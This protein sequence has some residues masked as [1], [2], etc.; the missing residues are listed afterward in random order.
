M[1]V[2]RSG[3]KAH[4]QALCQFVCTDPPKA[5]Y[6]EH[7]GKHHP[8]PW[9]LEVQSHLR[10]QRLPA[11]PGS[12]IA[13]GFDQQGLSAVVEY[14]F[15]RSEEQFIITAL[16]VAQRCQRRRYGTEALQYVLQ[17]LRVTRVNEGVDCGVFARIDPRND[18]S[19][20]L[21]DRAGFEY[22]GLFGGYEM[23]VSDL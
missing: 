1:L 15:S 13:L 23:W 3:T 10:G 20:S 18:A 22:I 5:N 21:F 9:E 17:S 2:W 4:Q 11:P 16:A 19:R 6:D 7:R 12:A 8:R 14:A